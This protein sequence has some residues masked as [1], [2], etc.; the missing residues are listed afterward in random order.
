[1]FWEAMGFNYQYTSSDG[2][3]YNEDDDI[4][5]WMVKGVNGTA[6][7]EPVVVVD[8]DDDDEELDESVAEWP[9]SLADS[10]EIA[11]Y[12]QNHSTYDVD[13]EL[14]DEIYRG[15]HAVLRKVPLLQIDPGH[16]DSNIS[17]PAKTKRYMKM[18]PATM[19]PILIEDGVVVDGHHRYRVAKKLGLTEIW[20]YVIED[21]P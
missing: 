16:A 10:R 20:C 5:W 18:D 7:P 14:I 17:D 11:D 4:W 13:Y 1:M 3:S 6:T 9:Q 19:P 15:M 21:Q 12:V 8:D 2:G